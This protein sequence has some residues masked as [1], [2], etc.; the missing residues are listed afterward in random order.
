MSIVVFLTDSFAMPTH[1]LPSSWLRRFRGLAL[2]R[3]LA[4]F[5]A[6]ALARRDPGA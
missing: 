5:A 1:P 6:H 3:E 2:F 4:A